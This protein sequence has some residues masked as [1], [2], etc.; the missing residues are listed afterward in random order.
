MPKSSYPSAALD[1][2]LGEGDLLA[3]EVSQDENEKKKRLGQM[4]AQTESAGLASQM[5]GLFRG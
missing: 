5:L 1:L 2:G 3:N 4:A